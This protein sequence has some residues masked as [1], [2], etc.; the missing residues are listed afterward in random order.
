[1]QLLAITCVIIG[2]EKSLVCSRKQGHR[3]NSEIVRWKLKF[4]CIFSQACVERMTVQMGVIDGYGLV[5]F[6]RPLGEKRRSVKSRGKCKC[7][8]QSKGSLT[9]PF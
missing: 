5:W 2:Q 4:I 1:M 3:V 7:M 8:R 9:K 6:P